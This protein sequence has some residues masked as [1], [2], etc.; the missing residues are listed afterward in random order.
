MGAASDAGSASRIRTFPPPDH[1]ERAANLAN[2]M[3]NVLAGGS[4]P[5]HRAYCVDAAVGGSDGGNVCA[6]AVKRA[7][8]WRNAARAARPLWL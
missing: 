2:D 1:A 8:G 6:K 4:T 3:R 7:G 5:T